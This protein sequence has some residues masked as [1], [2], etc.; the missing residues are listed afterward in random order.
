MKM[1]RKILLEELKCLKSLDNKV[2]LSSQALKELHTLS[3]D[4]LKYFYEFAKIDLTTRNKNSANQ[5]I[6]T[7]KR[8]LQLISDIPCSLENSTTQIIE[9]FID[10][11]GNS[12][13]DIQNKVSHLKA[14]FDCAN[15]DYEIDFKQFKPKSAAP[16]K[17]ISRIKASDISKAIEKYTLII[18]G[19]DSELTD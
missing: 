6:S 7:T 11:Y 10:D 16:I 1:D 4:N 12:A 3:N 15:F 18:N 13:K 5:Y 2:L 8:Y 19:N 14:L 9:S 17:K